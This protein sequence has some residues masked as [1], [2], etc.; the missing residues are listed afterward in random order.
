[1]T[2]FLS[3]SSRWEVS[4]ERRTGLMQSKPAP[5]SAEEKLRLQAQLLNVVE[6]AMLVVDL[7]GHILFWNRFAETL[8]GWT[9]EEVQ[10]RL[11]GEV[12][13]APLLMESARA[14]LEQLRRGE[15]WSGEFRIQR[16]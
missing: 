8:Y 6:Q 1:M 9:D 13:A 3:R 7:T 15:G 4:R 10:G 2:R 12:F 14:N 11:I 5:L 16:R